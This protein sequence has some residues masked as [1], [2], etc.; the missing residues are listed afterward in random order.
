MGYVYGGTQFDAHLPWPETKRKRAYPRLAKPAK[1][2]TMG[3]FAK[4]RR[5]DTKPCDPCADVSRAYNAEW[6]RRKKAGKV[7]TGWVKAA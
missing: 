2:G 4:H 1:C 6:K 5:E 3:G 7:T